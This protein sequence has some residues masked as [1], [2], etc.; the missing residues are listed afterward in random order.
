MHRPSLPPAP[1]PHATHTLRGS[2]GVGPS[3]S[4]Q[5]RVHPAGELLLRIR[6]DDSKAQ[7]PMSTKFGAALDEVPR[8]LRVATELGLRVRGVSFHVGSGCLSPDA[9]G[10]AVASAAHVHDLAAAAG[11]PMA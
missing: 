7:C 8:L 9:Y 1:Y 3:H 6:V 11:A 5:A 2:Y 10:E 4:L